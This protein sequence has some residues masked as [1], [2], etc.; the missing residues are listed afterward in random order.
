MIDK[1]LEL[2]QNFSGYKERVESTPRTKV[3]LDELVAE[4]TPSKADE[5]KREDNL[6]SAIN[7]AEQT[8]EN[9][10]SDTVSS[11][12]SSEQ[13]PT[14]SSPPSPEQRAEAERQEKLQERAA[15]ELKQL[16]KAAIKTRN[17]AAN[18]AKAPK[19]EKTKKPKGK[20]EAT[21]IRPPLPKGLFNPKPLRDQGPH[22]RR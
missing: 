10:P 8:R 9:P 5:E 21:T 13:T 4:K 11:P 20:R 2:Y 14:V 18:S 7:Q 19:D 15:K 6:L 16:I 22:K 3:N 17:A 1:F 12:S